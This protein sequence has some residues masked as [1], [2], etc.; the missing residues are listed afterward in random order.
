MVVFSSKESCIYLPSTFSELIAF[1]VPSATNRSI[2]WKEHINLTPGSDYWL[3]LA[4]CT[5]L[6]IFQIR[7][8]NLRQ[9]G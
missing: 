4:H 8:L 7:R 5:I 6:P 9:V 1:L 3:L 2:Y